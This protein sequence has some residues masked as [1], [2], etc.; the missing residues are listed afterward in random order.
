[1][2][3]H[4]QH[5][6]FQIFTLRVI[7]VHRMIGRL[8]ALVQNAHAAPRHGRRREHGRAEVVLCHDLRAGECKQNASMP[9]LLTRLCIELAIALQGVAQGVFVF[10]ES[11]G[12]EYNQIILKCVLLVL[13]LH[14]HRLLQ[15]TA[16]VVKIC[17]VARRP[18]HLFRACVQGVV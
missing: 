3:F 2:S 14:Q 6:P 8:R 11:R 12:I 18:F 16:K 7:D 9:N 13:F 15:A 10:G 5:Q 17:E 4:I 1:M